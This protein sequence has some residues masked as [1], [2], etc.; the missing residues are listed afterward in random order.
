MSLMKELQ[1]A[2]EAKDLDKVMSMIDDDIEIRMLHTNASM[3]GPEALGMIKEMV[4]D[5]G[6]LSMDFRLIYENNE[7][8]VTWERIQ[9]QMSGQVSIVQLFRNNK[10]YYQE[11]SLIQDT[12]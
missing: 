8:A 3:K 5:E 7:C 10:I 12:Q 4:L 6:T 2:W 11:G 1:A 9:G